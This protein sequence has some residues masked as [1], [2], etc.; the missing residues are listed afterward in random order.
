M[1]WKEV[2][3]KEEEEEEEAGANLEKEKEEW[4]GGKCFLTGVFFFLRPRPLF[5]HPKCDPY[6][7]TYVHVQLV[8]VFGERPP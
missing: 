8:F 5:T 2:E 7:T 6:Y 1:H 3:K 4:G